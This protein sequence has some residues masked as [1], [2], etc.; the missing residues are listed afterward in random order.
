[1]I[2]ADD[3]QLDDTAHNYTDRIMLDSDLTKIT[4]SGS[5]DAI[6]TSSTGGNVSMLV[7]I[8][9]CHGTATMVQSKPDNLNALDINTTTVS[10]DLILML[11]PYT[12]GTPLPTTSIVG[13]VVSVQWSSGQIDHI[14]VTPNADGRTRLA[15]ARPTADL[16]PPAITVPS[17]IVTTATTAQGNVINF[18]VS[19]SDSV[20]GTV[21]VLC[22]PPSGSVFPIGTTTVVCSAKDSSLNAS[23]ATFTITVQPGAF[24]LTAPNLVATPG[25]QSA[26]LSWDLL[27][28]ASGYNLYR[29]LTSGSGFSLLAGGLSSTSYVDTGL[30]EGMPY[31]YYVSGS[32]GA[33]EGPDSSVASIVPV[34]VPPPWLDMDI[35]TVGLSGSSTISAARVVTMTAAGTNPGGAGDSFH[36]ASQPWKGNC[37]VLARFLGFGKATTWS[38]AGIMLRQSQ[39][40]NSANAFMGL[41]NFSSQYFFSYRSNPGAGTNSTGI[42]HAGLPQWLKLVLNG[43]TVT[44]Y[45]AAASFPGAQA[46]VQVGAP[47]NVLLS[48]TFYAGLALSSNSTTA[49]C[50]GTFDSVAIYSPPSINVP[51]NLNLQATGTYGAVANFIVTGSSN[52]DGLLTGNSAPASGIAF[53]VGTTHVTATVTDSAGDLTSGT[54]AITVSLPPAPVISSTL[55]V[56]CVSGT[57]FGYSIS[58]S[59]SP[60]SYDAIGLPPGLSVNTTT[61]LISGTPTGTGTSSVILSAANVGGTGSA[62]M[63]LTVLP[64]S[65]AAPV[66]QGALTGQGIVGGLCSYQILASNSPTSFSVTNLPAGLV[67][68]GVTGLISG[69][70]LTAGTSSVALGATNAAGTGSDVLN[71]TVLPAAPMITS[72]LN[73]ALNAGAAF[74]YQISATNGPTSY[75]ASGL[76]NGLSVNT[77][78]GLIS[79]TAQSAGMVSVNI[80]ATNAGGTGAATLSLTV[81]PPIIFWAASGTS[82]A[83]SAGSN[84]IGGIAPG[85]SLTGSVAGFDQTS[86]G[87]QPNAGTTSIAGLQVGDGITATAG[88]SLAGSNLT[89]G[90]GGFNV[91]MNSGSTSISSAVTIGTSQTWVNNSANVLTVSGGISTG[92]NQLVI[93]GTGSTSLYSISGT[94]GVLMSGS[95]GL[96][97]NNTLG[98]A[99]QLFRQTSG[100]VY[101]TNGR[102]T[103]ANI[104]VDGGTF[105]VT[106]GRYSTGTNLQTLSVKGGQVTY[107]SSGGYGIRLN[108]DNGTSFG[109]N[110]GVVFTGNQ[111]GGTVSISGGGGGNFNMGNSTGGDVT[112]YNLSGTGILSITNGSNWSIGADTAGSSTTVF[113]MSG[114]KLLVSNGM[115]GAQGTGARQ[116]FVWTGGTLAT[117]SYVATNLTSGTAIPVSATSRTLANGGGVLAPGDLGMPGYT[118]ITGNYAVTS[119]NAV[120]AIDLS[121]TTPATAFQDS[122]TKYDNV[123]VSGTTTLGGAVSVALINSFMPSS[124]STFTILTAGTFSGSFSNVP[125]GSRVTTA[126][127]LGSFVVSQIGNTISLGNFVQSGAKPV[128]TSLTATSITDTSAMLNGLVNASG[129]SAAVSFEYG[130]T[131]AYGT[132]VAGNPASVTGTTT[133]AVSAIV[134]S[135]TPGSGYHFRVAGTSASGGTNGADATFGTL[136]PIPVI[137]SASIATATD[138]RTFSYQIIASGG[139][140]SYNAEGLPPGLSIN[141]TTGLISGTP[142]AMGTFNA[143]ITASDSGGTRAASLL[144]TIVAPPISQAETAAPRITV[145]GGNVWL[146][147]NPT[148][149]GRTYKIQSSETLQPG[150]WVDVSPVLS[151]S[152]GSMT[153]SGTCSP[154]LRAE[155]Y[156]ILLG[157]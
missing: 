157:P 135:L 23:Q 60:T 105:N 91:A 133:L 101:L 136:P 2:V 123:A 128:V 87:F 51:S 68:N 84:W 18:A 125:F 10:P 121:G 6:V 53:P 45:D 130:P 126:D 148:V 73:S 104:E 113:N 80:G 35:G 72:A 24:P 108:G 43:T 153:L 14:A 86:Y 54:F 107:A 90:T 115:S 50:T 27:P 88:L 4:Y 112:T 12:N 102:S 83:W 94:G 40:A 37:T 20:D 63:T 55:N 46:W 58:A 1:M 56:A 38:E 49:T 3:I 137:S 41:Q 7:R 92:S 52:V 21:S 75:S 65:A 47:S 66:I 93:S 156:R 42:T 29:S 76:P 34:A 17:N 120:L 74:S 122:A 33:G 69:T 116:A 145:S 150:S 140:T 15:F 154:S 138:A 132:T 77:S 16:T 32:N 85:N 106:G 134:G 28:P 131:T 119:P 61:G 30:T 143:T 71:F 124:S 147:V 117:L 62:T 11:L 110:P 70:P 103:A 25:F 96:T 79:G 97:L 57:S 44:A 81:S 149:P 129:T 9:R 8:L 59:N 127:G 98:T 48:S 78:T 118:S 31:Y 139:A 141:T 142:K 144:I 100:T 111:S 155:F 19:G 89:I 22:D 109:G 5:T 13:N 67:L 95:G 151:G 26:A 114:G 146:T 36:F 82:T 39:A 99:G 64:P 152:G